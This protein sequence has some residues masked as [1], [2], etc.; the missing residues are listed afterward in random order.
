METEVKTFSH[1]LQSVHCANFDC[2]GEQITIRILHPASPKSIRQNDSAEFRLSS[3]WQM[4]AGNAGLETKW[5]QRQLAS[6]R[7]RRDFEPRQKRQT[8][9]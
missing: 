4:T 9:V 6:Y 5:K 3:C 1:D 2:A 8:R 7:A